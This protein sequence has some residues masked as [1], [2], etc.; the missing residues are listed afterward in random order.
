MKPRAGITIFLLGALLLG[1]LVLVPAQA[2]IVVQ[3][4][5]YPSDAMKVSE[6]Q[7]GLVLIEPDDPD[8]PQGVYVWPLL[9]AGVPGMTTDYGQY[10]IDTASNFLHYAAFG[11]TGTVSVSNVLDFWIPSR[12]IYVPGY[13]VV[14]AYVNKY[15]LPLSTGG[16]EYVYWEGAYAAG[17]RYVGGGS[18]SDIVPI[19]AVLQM[20]AT[21]C[22]YFIL[23]P[24]VYSGHGYTRVYFPASC[25]SSQPD[26]VFEYRTDTAY[27]RFRYNSALGRYE[28][29]TEKYQNEATWGTPY[30]ETLFGARYVYYE[31]TA[32]KDQYLR[33]DFPVYSSMVLTASDGHTFPYVY[34]GN[35]IG[36]RYVGTSPPAF[37]G[38]YTSCCQSGR[39]YISFRRVRKYP[40]GSSYIAPVLSSSTLTYYTTF[41]DYQVVDNDGSVPTTSTAS[42]ALL[43]WPDL[44]NSIKGMFS[45]LQKLFSLFA[46]LMGSLFSLATSV[47]SAF[48]A[49]LEWLGSVFS[50]LAALPSPWNT[51]LQFAFAIP[52]LVVTYHLL[53]GLGYLLAALIDAIWI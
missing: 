5:P 23:G 31:N 50:D 21:S 6:P 30:F 22:D 25:L 1:S 41:E 34:D 43:S 48:A 12:A 37:F 7:Y 9:R 28:V 8:N 33:Y 4:G 10:W 38:D 2:M 19:D 39:K 27:I 36:Y 51:A 29:N 47:L 17:S 24:R 45:W 15:F 46:S 49:G 35:E 40:S 16:D 42:G 20:S 52:V 44:W 13:D 18:S 14:P 32:V 53:K 11:A 26:T 3:E